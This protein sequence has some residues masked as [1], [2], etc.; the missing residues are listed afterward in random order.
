MPVH[1][2]DRLDG[3]AV[4]HQRRHRFATCERACPRTGVTRVRFSTP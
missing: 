4:T 1:A 2:D 3:G